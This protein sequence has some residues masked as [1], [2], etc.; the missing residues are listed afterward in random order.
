MTFPHSRPTERHLFVER[1]SVEGVCPECHEPDLQSYPV[2]A[3]AG[4]LDVVKCGKCLHSV[5]REPGP[6]LG[7]IRL[8]S[9]LV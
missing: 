8:I 9:D 1:R 2:L 6:R 4:W 3:E 7:A 5:S